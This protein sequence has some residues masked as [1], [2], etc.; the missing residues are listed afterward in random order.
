MLLENN[1]IETSDSNDVP[2]PWPLIWEAAAGVVFVYLLFL[3]ALP[4]ILISAFAFLACCIGVNEMFGRTYSTQHPYYL[5]VRK[6]ISGISIAM[7]LV[8]VGLLLAGFWHYQD[9]YLS[10]LFG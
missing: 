4:P 3:H 10:K 2:S 1:D 6:F 5:Q 8:A 9:H 7:G